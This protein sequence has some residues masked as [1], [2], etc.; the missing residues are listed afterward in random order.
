MTHNG[1]KCALELFRRAEVGNIAHADD[2]VPQFAFIGKQGR[3]CDAHGE[4]R[5]FRSLQVAFDVEC[6]I[7]CERPAICDCFFECCSLWFTNPTDNFIMLLTGD[8]RVRRLYSLS[9]ARLTRSM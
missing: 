1:Y 4:G 9:K 5:R 7:G 8:F 6:S 3:I 2:D